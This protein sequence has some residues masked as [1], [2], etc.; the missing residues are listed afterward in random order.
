M[1]ARGDPMKYLA[2]V[3]GLL[4]L[5]VVPAHADSLVGPPYNVTGSVVF[6]GNNACGGVCMETVNFSFTFQW[7][8][9]TGVFG[10]GIYGSYIPGSFSAT[11]SGSMGSAPI[12]MSNDGHII[13]CGPGTYIPMNA[14]NGELDLDVS[15][16]G[17]SPNPGL[18]TVGDAFLF[19][20]NAQCFQDFAPRIGVNEGYTATY[21]VTAAPEPA[22]LGMLAAGLAFAA[23][24]PRLRRQR[25]RRG[26]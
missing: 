13:C 25:N 18:P 23:M 22:S 12:T 1:H 19:S 24:I 20:C 8:D 10:P 16:F 3:V 4:F 6:T 7:V 9:T 11:Q 26:R 2:A 21:T 14:F 17:S 5:A 15:L